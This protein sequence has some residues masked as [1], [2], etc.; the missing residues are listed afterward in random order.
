VRWYRHHVVASY[1]PGNVDPLPSTALFDAL[2][3]ATANFQ[4]YRQPVAWYATD[5]ANQVQAADFSVAATS[6]RFNSHG[7]PPEYKNG[8]H[9]ATGKEGKVPVKT[10]VWVL[11]LHCT[12]Y[13]SQLPSLRKG[14][15]N[16]VLAGA[17][18]VAHLL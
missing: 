10:C 14:V 9:R 1:Q 2:A 15:P 17:L 12:A 3:A 13:C 18:L 8:N 16:S 4:W 5:V 6:L 7:K 11:Y